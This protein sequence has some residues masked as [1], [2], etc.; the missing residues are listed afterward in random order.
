M[1]LAAGRLMTQRLAG[2]RPPRRAHHVG[3]AARWNRVAHVLTAVGGQGALLL[4]FV[5]QV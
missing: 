4:R 1:E 5:R 3:P 2:C